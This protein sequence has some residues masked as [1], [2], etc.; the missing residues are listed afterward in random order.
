MIKKGVF[1]TGV[2][3]CGTTTVFDWLLQS[4]DFSG[5]SV[6]EPQFFCLDQHTIEDYFQVYN[7]IYTNS[8]S[9]LDGSTLYC[10]YPQSY[11]AIKSKF[12]NPKFI[13]CLRDPVK[14]FYSAFWFM[15]GMGE[16]YESRNLN[17]ILNTFEQGIQ[18]NHSIIE[19]EN[20]I[21]K[22]AKVEKSIYYDFINKTYHKIRIGVDIPTTLPDDLI[23]FRYAQESLYKSVIENAKAA[24]A[25][26]IW[27]EDLLKDPSTILKE[28]AEFTE[29]SDI[30][31]LSLPDNS[32]ISTVATSRFIA[33]ATESLRSIRAQLNIQLP[34][35]FTKIVKSNLY[36]RAPKISK[37]E[38][39]RI[40]N[41]LSKSKNYIDYKT[42]HNEA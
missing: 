34:K 37:E 20:E 41:I 40:E 24:Q 30:P 8:T 5:I 32:N 28:I 26:I 35:R 15:K 6:K 33:K 31:E 16:K 1:V 18:N 25:K 38:Y 29:L 9:V 14:R 2:R 42:Y 13:V 10:Q 17:D 12:H 11:S 22:R 7:R 19:T 27:L 4:N 21:L 39:T 23:F 3:K 36:E